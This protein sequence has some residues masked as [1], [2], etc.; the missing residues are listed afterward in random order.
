[1][2]KT[3][4]VLL[5]AAVVAGGVLTA[6]PAHAAAAPLCTYPIHIPESQTVVVNGLDV[7][8]NPNGVTADADAVYATAVGVYW[9][10]WC[11]E[12]GVVTNP[13]NC[14]LGKAYEIATSIDPNTGNFRYIS[15]DPNTGAVTLHGEQLAA[16][17]TAC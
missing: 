12:D 7:T 4:N 11:V 5:A 1:M 3:W 2:G 8:V 16:D 9:W 6:A 17:L 15:R 14:L 13:A 10:V